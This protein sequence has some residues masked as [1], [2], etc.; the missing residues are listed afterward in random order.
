[1]HSK[2]TINKMKWQPTDQAS[3]ENDATDK[4]L[5]SK[6]YKQLIQPNKKKK[7]ETKN[8]IKLSRRPR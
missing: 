6:I 7:A 4:A 1:M 8:L 3:L 5:I 2:G